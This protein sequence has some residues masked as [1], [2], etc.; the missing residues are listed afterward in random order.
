MTGAIN[1]ELRNR[2]AFAELYVRQDWQKEWLF[3]S[4]WYVFHTTC[5]IYTSRKAFAELYAGQAGELGGD[6]AAVPQEVCCELKS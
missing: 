4:I 6:D 3:P 2:K 1:V 5:C